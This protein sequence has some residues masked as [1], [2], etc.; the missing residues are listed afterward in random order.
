M[1]SAAKRRIGPLTPHLYTPDARRPVRVKLHWLRTDVEVVPHSHPW[2]Q[3]GFSTTGVTRL[4]VAGGSYIAP[5][6]RAV[7]VPPG[8]EHAVVALADADLRSI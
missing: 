6:L 8:V 5:P 1:P 4:T 7:W 2:G 3:V